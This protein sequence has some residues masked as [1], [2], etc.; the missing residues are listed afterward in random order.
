MKIVQAYSQFFPNYGGIE[1]HIYSISSEL[2]KLGHTSSVLTT[3]L[4]NFQHS[5]L[6]KEAIVNGIRVS[7]L[8]AFNIASLTVCPFFLTR[9]EILDTC[10]VVHS[11]SLNTDSIILPLEFQRLARNSPV[12]VTPHF[13]PKR[14]QIESAKFRFYFEKIALKLLKKANAV[15]ALTSSE[16][17]YYEAKGIK[18]VYEIPNGVDLSSHF[19]KKEKLEPFEVDHDPEKTKILFVGRFV[20]N[21][22]L[23]LAIRCLPGI[24]ANNKDVILYAVGSYTKHASEM[25]ALA[26]KLGCSKKI[27]FF[28]N[29]NDD[30]LP[31]FFECSNL[32]ILP[33]R[34]E[35]FGIVILESWAHK[36]PIIVSNNGGMGDVVS[37]GGGIVMDSYQKEKW[38]SCITSLL[39]DETGLREMGEEG[40]QILIRKYL[41]SIIAEKLVDVYSSVQR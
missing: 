22:N 12:I 20:K 11:H 18:N 33:S 30:E 36:K 27:R 40:Y 38:S 23:E 39:N 21:K 9:P 37:W 24:L 34:Y 25:K 28:F 3:D 13:H 26:D 6:C 4:L 31:Y 16:K 5:A 19:I 29:V 2:N 32:T 7:R 17:E 15:I 1:K 8:F 14:L 41:W 10:N 35:A